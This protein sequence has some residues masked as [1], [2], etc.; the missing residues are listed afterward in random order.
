MSLVDFDKGQKTVASQSRRTAGYILASIAV[1]MFILS[2]SLGGNPLNEWHGILLWGGLIFLCFQ[3]LPAKQFWSWVVGLIIAF[4]VL[5]AARS[6]NFSSVSNRTYED[7]LNDPPPSGGQY[8]NAQEFGIKI[9]QYLPLTSDLSSAKKL[10][11]CLDVAE[12]HFSEVTTSQQRK[13][14]CAYYAA[15]TKAEAQDTLSGV[16]LRSDRRTVYRFSFR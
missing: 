14:G 9:G 11:L 10:E 6:S 16:F 15:A 7:A 3:K 1:G 8:L 13:Q 4:V 2:L 5:S 12:E